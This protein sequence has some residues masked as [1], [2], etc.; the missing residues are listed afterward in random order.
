MKKP[1]VKIIAQLYARLRNSFETAV[2]LGVP[3]SKAKTEGERM[4][5][6]PGVQ[7]SLK[8][9][10]NNLSCSFSEVRA[11]LVRLAFG[12]VNDPVALVF[13]DQ[14]TPYA[15]AH[16]DLFNVSEIKRVK[17]GGVEVK[18]FDRQKALEKLLELDDKLYGDSKGDDFLSAVCR[19]SDDDIS[20]MLKDGDDDDPEEMSE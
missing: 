16:S 4:V 1:T 13:S 3:P 12:S 19:T 15:I 9:I 18:F 8:N 7:K 20:Y 5:S 17:G 11:G 2:R 10:E 14:P 6:T